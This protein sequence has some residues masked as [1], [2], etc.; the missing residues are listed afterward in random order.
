MQQTMKTTRPSNTMK[1]ISACSCIFAALALAGMAFALSG[2]GKKDAAGASS[3]PAKNNKRDKDVPE[4]QSSVVFYNSFLGFRGVSQS[5]FEKL[6]K[7]IARGGEYI[8][9]NTGDAMPNWDGV[10]APDSQIA[11]IPG[12]DFAAPGD[13]AKKDRAYIDT[14]LEAVRKDVAALLK[15]IEAMKTYYRAGDYKDDWHKAFLM[16]RPRL[17]GL[18]A[19]IAKNNK[20]VYK[21]ADRLSEETDRK[22]IARAPDGVFILNMRHVID[23]ARERADLIL[24]NNLG[25]TRY[26]LGVPDDERRRMLARASGICDKFDALTREIDAMCAKYKTADKKVIKGSPAEKIYDGF[27]TSCEKSGD[28]MRRIVR[29]LRERGYTNDQNTIGGAVGGLVGAHNE[30]LKSRGG[31]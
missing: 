8:G 27:F 30:F 31:K 28:D 10:I 11:K 18:M 14:R 15:E 22:N 12:Y 23:K 4:G 26:G 7:A 29:E 16:A 21:L 9:R 17:E 3:K 13:F 25:D 2:C 5:V 19:R 6:E 1:K 24:D 20:E